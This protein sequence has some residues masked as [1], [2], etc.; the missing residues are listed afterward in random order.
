M[1]KRHGSE[2]EQPIYASD[3]HKNFYGAVNNVSHDEQSTEVLSDK[4]RARLKWHY[5]NAYEKY[6][7]GGRKPW[8]LLIQIIKIF[9]VTA[10]VCIE[11]FCRLYVG[12]F[13]QLICLSY[14][15]H[16]RYIFMI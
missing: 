1:A 16:H 7:A 15:H 8:K 13:L 3:F 4:M 11:A 9:L 2:Q 12:A 5:M 6:K 14:D 10:Q